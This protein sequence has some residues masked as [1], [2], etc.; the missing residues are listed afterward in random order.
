ML[1]ILFELVGIIIF[2][3]FL[4]LFVWTILFFTFSS[5]DKTAECFKELGICDSCKLLSRS[6][7]FVDIVD[8]G[9]RNVEL[10]SVLQKSVES[11][12]RDVTIFVMIELVPDLLSLLWGKTWLL[13]LVAL[14]LKE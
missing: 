11:V 9:V 5:W 10:C 6:E 13:L 14:S 8:V 1:T 2:T 12:G 3:C 7:S 4:L